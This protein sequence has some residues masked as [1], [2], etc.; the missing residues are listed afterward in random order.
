MITLRKMVDDFFVDE[1]FEGR[2]REMTTQDKRERKGG[3]EALL[4]AI[5][6]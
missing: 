4:L 2:K 6:R 3:S 5:R 1:T